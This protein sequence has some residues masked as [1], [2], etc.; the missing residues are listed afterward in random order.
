MGIR[1]SLV[2]VAQSDCSQ[3]WAH[4]L[5]LTRLSVREPKAMDRGV[6]IPTN[7][8]KENVCIPLGTRF[9]GL[10]CLIVMALCKYRELLSQITCVP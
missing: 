6:V 8:Y 7:N 1:Q 5:D 4:I 3:T 10:K 2:L 9:C